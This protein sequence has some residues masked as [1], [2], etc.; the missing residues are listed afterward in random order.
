MTNNENQGT[1]CLFFTLETGITLIAFFI[2]FSLITQIGLIAYLKVSVTPMIAVYLLH[3]V[4]FFV[5]HWGL[6][7]DST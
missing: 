7:F 2:L 3:C 5:V 6:G 4:L 1:C